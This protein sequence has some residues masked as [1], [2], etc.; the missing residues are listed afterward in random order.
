MKRITILIGALALFVAACGGGDDGGAGTTT[1]TTAPETVDTYALVL[2]VRFEGGFAPIENV[3]N[4]QPQ[5]TLYADGKLLYPG[6]VPE[7]FPGPMFVPYRMVELDT[8]QMADL[9]AAIEATGLPGMTDE[10]L[11]ADEGVA[12]APDTVF[13]YV[14]NSLHRAA[15][16]AL[17]ISPD[18]DPAIAP[19]AELYDMLIDLSVTEAS[20]AWESDRYQVIVTPSFGVENDELATVQPWPVA[21]PAADIPVTGFGELQCAVLVGEEAAEAGPVFLGANSMTFFED[22]GETYRLTVRPLL[23]QEEGCPT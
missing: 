17:G 16:Y 23:P 4:P 2:E 14:D 22:G 8:R 13:R 19:F 12:D 3:Y 6:P 15:V 5:F 11:I 18:Q 21:T 9:R 7:I 10:R 1:P 20:T